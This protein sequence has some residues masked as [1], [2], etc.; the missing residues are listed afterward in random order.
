MTKIKAVNI[1]I[2]LR[3]TNGFYENVIS[4]FRNDF[5]KIL[6][7]ESNGAIKPIIQEFPHMRDNYG[8]GIIWF[9]L[10][11]NIPIY[12]DI[13]KIIEDQVDNKLLASI[14]KKFIKTNRIL[15]EFKKE[16]ERN[17]TKSLREQ[18]KMNLVVALDKIDIKK[19]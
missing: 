8:Y 4:S 14:A 7:K 16:L 10:Y 6:I 19:L 17:I 12:I 3:V 2:V 18:D 13:H 1:E 15:S 9:Y 5:M 11:I